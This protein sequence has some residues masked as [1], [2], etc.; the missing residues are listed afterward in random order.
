M[1]DEANVSKVD[2]T[3]NNNSAPSGKKKYC[4]KCYK[5]YD[6]SNAQCPYCGH[7]NKHTALKVAIGV[8][9]GGTILFGAIP[10]MMKD[11]DND[12]SSNKSIVATE[13]TSAT[14]DNT[15]ETKTEQTSD[16]SQTESVDKPIETTNL[17]EITTQVIK[18]TI[19]TQPTTVLVTTSNDISLGE[20]NALVSAKRYIDSLDFS[21][22]RLIEQLEYE[23]FSHEEAVYGADNCGANWNDEALGCA[24]SYIK[25]NDFSYISLKKQ[26]EY[27]DFTPEQ[28]QYALDNCNADYKQEAVGTAKSYI[29]MGGF[30]KDTLLEQLLFEGYTQEE[31]EYA[32]SQVGY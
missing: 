2:E 21:Y 18:T 25:T 31:A 1:I 23:K 24:L 10:D 26:L 8:M 3:E 15:S 9:V 22:S 32:I 30:S 20:T 7:K 5:Q 27:E 12:S 16:E 14:E 19:V 13:K 28:V 29:S 17:E 11:K 6:A 4:E